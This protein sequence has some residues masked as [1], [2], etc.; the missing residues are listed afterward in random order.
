[1]NWKSFRWC[2]RAP[3]RDSSFI[4]MLKSCLFI[5]ALI[6][7]WL[8][9]ET[10]GQPRADRTFALERREVPGEL[11]SVRLRDLDGDGIQDLVYVAV[12]P[13]RRELGYFR[14][15]VGGGFEARPAHRLRLKPDVIL[16][17]I[18]DLDSAPGVEFVLIGPTSV[19]VYRHAVAPE[20]GRYRRLFRE[21]L[22]YSFADPD[23]APIWPFIRDLDGDGLED[24]CLPAWDGYAFRFQSRASEG[25]SDF[26]RVSRVPTWIDQGS[27]APRGRR[28]NL[29]VSVSGRRYARRSD[30]TAPPAEGFMVESQRRMS[31][32][33]L[34]D[35]NGDGRLDLML[36]EGHQLRVW[37]Q[38][39]DRSFPQAPSLGQDLEKVLTLAPRWARTGNLQFAEL[40]GDRRLDFLVRQAVKKNIRTRLL[41][42]PGGVEKL[43][44]PPGRIFI[45]NGLTSAPRFHDVNGDGRPDLLVPTY[46]LDLLERAK[47]AAVRSLDV[48]LYLFLNR[49]E[50]V[51]PSRPD[52]NRTETLRTD[53][54]AES[55]V[56]PMLYLDGDFNRD[57]RAD[58]VVLDEDDHLKVYLSTE[59]EGG[60]FSSGG[61]FTF[62]D[63]PAV[64]IRVEVPRKIRLIDQD[65]DGVSE[66][67]MLYERGFILGGWGLGRERGR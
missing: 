25:A 29:A 45:L 21:T 54:L 49:G 65:Q 58:L 66:I 53:R 1:M 4:P 35:E 47:Q 31:S 63:E 55:G 52:Y 12:E 2:P 60:L 28:V 14:G 40:D 19:F 13:G 30:S 50:E 7:S 10:S 51:Y 56:E 42:F 33:V 5:L 34:V 15:R 9:A 57:G 32:P 67:L 26:S 3:S 46:R 17:G 11:R 23:D 27:A 18:G 41:L 62:Q 24:L 48:T 59:T 39:P 8:V 20:A 6:G 38:N 64:S 44:G 36:L 16:V 37:R 43:Q 22:F 61:D